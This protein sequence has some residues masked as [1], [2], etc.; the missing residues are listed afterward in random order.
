MSSL[1][2]QVGYDPVCFALLNDSRRNANNSARRRP[3]PINI[4]IIA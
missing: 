1:A 3:Q 4:A 2:D